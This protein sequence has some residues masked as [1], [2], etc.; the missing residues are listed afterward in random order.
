MTDEH[1][2]ALGD[3]VWSYQKVP[4]EVRASKRLEAALDANKPE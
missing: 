4:D 2:K 3:A 1:A